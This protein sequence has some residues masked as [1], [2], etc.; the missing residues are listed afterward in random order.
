MFLRA[1]TKTHQSNGVDLKLCVYVVRCTVCYAIYCGVI[2]SRYSY[3][4]EFAFLLE[5]QTKISN[6]MHVHILNII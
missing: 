6:Q 3:I 5:T 1:H 4:Y 2:V